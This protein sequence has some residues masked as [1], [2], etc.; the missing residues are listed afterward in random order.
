M[1]GITVEKLYN[2]R[3][4]ELELTALNSNQAGMKK[5]ISTVRGWH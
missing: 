2:S 5:V 4:Q 1:V 3:N